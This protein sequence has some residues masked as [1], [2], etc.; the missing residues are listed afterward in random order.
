MNRQKL[1]KVF[2]VDDNFEAIEL[3][4]HML[5]HD[6]SVEVV[7]TAVDA[8]EAASLRT[9]ARGLGWKEIVPRP[10]SLL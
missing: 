2:I 5:E 7:G 4:R 6:Y 1:T 8:E 9:W 10:G 3:L